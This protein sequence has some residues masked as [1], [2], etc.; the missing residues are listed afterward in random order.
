MGTHCGAAR[1]RQ[2]R[3]PGNQITQSAEMGGAGGKE[4]EPDFPFKYSL[5]LLM[6]GFF[7]LPL[8]I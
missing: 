2:R 8:E 4:A 6:F 7:F 1:V 3:L 5:S